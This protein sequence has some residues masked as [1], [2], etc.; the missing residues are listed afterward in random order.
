MNQAAPMNE[1]EL[2]RHKEKLKS[3]SGKGNVDA[4]FWKRIGHLIKYVVPNWYC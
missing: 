2:A 4:E 1:E 3:R